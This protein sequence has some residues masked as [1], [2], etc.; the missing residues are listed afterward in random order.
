[1]SAGSM[2]QSTLGL[3]GL[4]N[5]KAGLELESGEGDSAA[6]AFAVE[7]GGSEGVPGI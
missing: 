6:A 1:M 4:G 2:I 3:L 5:V 7:K